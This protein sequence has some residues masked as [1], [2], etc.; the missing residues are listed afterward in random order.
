MLE[1][2]HIL[3]NKVKSLV[4]NIWNFNFF[5]FLLNNN[6]LEDEMF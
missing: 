6:I 1:L 2:V 3:T 5:L 4:I